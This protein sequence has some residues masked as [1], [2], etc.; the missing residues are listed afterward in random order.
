MSFAT[1]V[2]KS[3]AGGCCVPAPAGSAATARVVIRPWSRQ[4]D[5]P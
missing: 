3:D 4:A 1:Y 5:L 2:L